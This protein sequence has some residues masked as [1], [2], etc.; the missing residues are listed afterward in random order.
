MVRDTEYLPSGSLQTLKGK[1]RSAQ[2]EFQTD[3]RGAA[4][5]ALQGVIDFINKIPAFESNKLSLP[6]TALMAALHD[7]DT[8]RVGKIVRPKKA[9]ELRNRPRDA[10]FRN[11]V[12]AYSIFAVDELHGHGMPVDHACKY[13]TAE[14]ERAGVPIGG[15]SN[16]PSWKTVR[17]W[18]NDVSRRRA[19]DQLRNTLDALKNEC[20]FP[21][22]MPLAQL[23]SQ[24]VQKLRG[25]LPILQ[26]SLG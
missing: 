5:T 2:A 9:P 13:V 10:S 19:D 25:T 21:S 11:V 20:R 23:K 6:L 4:I 22:D 26:A 3:C 7:L 14:L 18:R 24:L 8:G 12:K 1:L 17:T 15:R 16:T